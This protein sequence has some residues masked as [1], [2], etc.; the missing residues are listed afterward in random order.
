MQAYDK[1]DW[2]EHYLAQND[3]KYPTY[4]FIRSNG[5]GSGLMW[6]YVIYAGHIRYALCRNMIPVVDMKNYPNAY[7]DPKDLGIVNVWENYFEQPMGV[8]IEEAIETAEA[9]KCSIVLSRSEP[10]GYHVQNKAL[11]YEQSKEIYNWRALREF[12]LLRVKKNILEHIANVRRSIINDNDRVLGV[13]LRGTE[14]T[15]THPFEHP[16]QP[17]IEFAI[18]TVMEKAK[19]WSCNKIFL[20]TEDKNYV[21]IFKQVFGGNIVTIPKAY[22]E[23]HTEDKKSYSSYVN[24]RDNDYYLKGLEYLTEMTILAQCPNIVSSRTTGAAATN[25]LAKG[26]EH[27][28]YFFL[29]RYGVIWDE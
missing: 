16:V 19:E 6:Y 17:P 14:Y 26:F 9:G 23:Y 13:M 18:R 3:P 10:M 21:N 11:L 12:G 24:E 15:N 28:Y 25:I 2:T 22:A 1:E 29:G 27:K 20:A 7:Q 5:S 8:G 4:Y